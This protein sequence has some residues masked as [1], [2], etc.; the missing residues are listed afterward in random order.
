LCFV[1]GGYGTLEE[2]LEVITWAQLGIHKKPVTTVSDTL[3]DP[4]QN[5]TRN[6]LES[7]AVPPS[8]RIPF[9]L[10]IL[11]PTSLSKSRLIR[12]TV[13]FCDEHLALIMASWHTVR[14]CDRLGFWMSRDKLLNY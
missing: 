11:Y 3:L 10:A 13:I 9:V 14:P 4:N 6:N 5:L 8:F 7:C 1:A 2:L 12:D